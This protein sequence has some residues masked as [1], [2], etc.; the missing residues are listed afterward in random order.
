M[1]LEESI[2]YTFKDR[3][4][5]ERAL[6]TPA[7]RMDRPEV[8][9]NQRLEFLGDAVFG[10]LS[11]EAVFKTHPDEQ[12]GPLTVRR[13]HLVSTVALADAAE[14]L[15][16]R[17]FLK[18]NSGATELPPRAKV[19]TDSLEALMGAAWLD[20][21]LDAA[22]TVF[23]SLN[24]PVEDAFDAWRSNPKGFLQVKAQALK[25]S[26]KPVYEVV[27]IVGAAHAPV[28]T[29]KVSV[30]GLGEAEA[31]AVSKTAAEIAAAETML[32]KLSEQNTTSDGD[33]QNG[34]SAES[35]VIA[36]GQGS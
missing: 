8:K 28:V 7:C 34:K 32:K 36:D 6:T 31:T 35:S 26:R 18:R 15:G 21:G 5:L 12:E 20:G 30:A 23:R 27:R 17:R 1:E 3:S 24:L 9:D 29:V 13:A 10:L 2:G 33:C 14:T 16:L 25:P 22:R 11:A 4:L 19:L